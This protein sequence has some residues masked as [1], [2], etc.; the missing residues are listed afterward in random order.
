MRLS[1]FFFLHLVVLII[2]LIVNPH[3]RAHDGWV[4][5]ECNKSLTFLI[6]KK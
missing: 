2:L 4:I 1:L 3:A 5:D 6:H